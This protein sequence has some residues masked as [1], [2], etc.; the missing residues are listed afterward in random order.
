MSES[1]L[2]KLERAVEA[3]FQGALHEAKKQQLD[4]NE[5]AYRELVGWTLAMR[6]VLDKIAHIKRDDE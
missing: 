2:S 4:G 6:D 5:A 1:A 3:E